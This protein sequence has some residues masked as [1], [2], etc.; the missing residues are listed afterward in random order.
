MPQISNKLKWCINKAK[1][2]GKKHR[3]IR[4]IEPDPTRVKQH[5]NKAKHNLKVMIYLIKGNMHDWAISAS[6]YSMYHCLLAVLYKHGYESR[7]QECTFAAVEI[8]ID[9]KKIDLPLDKLRKISFPE[10]K[11]V[12]ES[13]AVIELREDA[14]YGTET[15][16]D[17]QKIHVLRQETAEFLDQ[18]QEMLERKK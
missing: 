2:E 11:E 18:V 10:R 17:L 7:N 14:Q 3:G 8:L 1:Q 12:L 6:F 13:N 5:I 9:E 4:V 16:Y 15:A